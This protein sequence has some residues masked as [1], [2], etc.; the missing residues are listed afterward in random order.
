M[1][2]LLIIFLLSF[3]LPSFGQI[4][5]TLQK[6]QLE[7]S[8]KF[9]LTTKIRSYILT[10]KVPNKNWKAIQIETINQR[11]EDSILNQLNIVRELKFYTGLRDVPGKINKNGSN[12]EIRSK[13]NHL[14]R[15]KRNSL[16]RLAADHCANKVIAYYF[17]NDRTHYAFFIYDP[18][19]KIE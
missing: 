11:P 8:I 10:Q 4:K 7:D 9:G 17:P 14:K 16:K 5:I 13:G 3:C 6:H 18:T 2:K 1:N 15:A 12:Y 19:I